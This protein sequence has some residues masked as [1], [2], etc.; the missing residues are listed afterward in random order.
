MFDVLS[1]FGK[2][3]G[4]WEVVEILKMKKREVRMF[5]NISPNNNEF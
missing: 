3:V 1:P 2:I 4:D 5:V